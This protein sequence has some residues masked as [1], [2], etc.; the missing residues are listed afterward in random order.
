M[1]SRC[2]IVIEA[3]SESDAARA[4]IAGFAEMSR[5]EQVLSDYREDSESMQLVR[6]EP[7]HWHHVSGT[8]FEVLGLSE[9]IHNRTSGAF[10]PAIGALTH[11]W[12][13]ADL[14]SRS[15]IIPAKMVL[16]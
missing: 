7:K 9:D 14:P 8:L 11:L 16:A 2:T 3:E 12:R 10:D 1:G 4:A 5:V 15:T 13:Q 6:R